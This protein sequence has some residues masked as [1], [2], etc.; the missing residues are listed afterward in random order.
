M[1]K[2]GIELGWKFYV[3]RLAWILVYGSSKLD[4]VKHLYLNL[5]R[6]EWEWWER[7]IGGVSKYWRIAIK[8]NLRRVLIAF[9]I[10]DSRQCQ[11]TPNKRNIFI[12]D[13]INYSKTDISL[14]LLLY[15]ENILF[16]ICTDQ[17]DKNSFLFNSMLWN[18]K[19]KKYY[20]KSSLN[21]IVS[22]VHQTQIYCT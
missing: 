17:T 2:T 3:K 18:V 8:W 16:S 12:A 6:K 20:A 10:D 21:L 15:F 13:S 14:S 11:T 1:P 4:I 19:Y 7:G 22:Y 5:C 9:V